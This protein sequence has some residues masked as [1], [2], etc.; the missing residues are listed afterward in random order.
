MAKYRVTSCVTISVATVI[1]AETPEIAMELA[2]A[3]SVADICASCQ[4]QDAES[5]W[6]PDSGMDGEIDGNKISAEEV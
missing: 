6:V 4:D 3:R 5:E 1:E 2:E